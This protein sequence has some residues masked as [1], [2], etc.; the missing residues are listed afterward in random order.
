M[1]KTPGDTGQFDGGVVKWAGWLK[2]AILVVADVK[3]SLLTS[4]EPCHKETKNTP[5]ELR[6]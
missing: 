2:G 5:A 3:T 4:S 1:E 6:A